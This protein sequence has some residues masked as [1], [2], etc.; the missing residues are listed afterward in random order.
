MVLLKQNKIEIKENNGRIKE[1]EVRNPKGKPKNAIDLVKHLKEEINKKP[2]GQRL[3]F[4]HIL[5]KKTIKDAIKGDKEARKLIF[6]YLEGTPI[7]KVEQTNLLESHILEVDEAESIEYR[8]FLEW[9][10]GRIQAQNNQDQ[11]FG[12]LNNKI[13]NEV[14]GL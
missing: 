6:G 4:A 7:Q 14:L 1:G 8:E 3:T 11:P 2:K 9:K 10:K 5:I 13:K 12:L